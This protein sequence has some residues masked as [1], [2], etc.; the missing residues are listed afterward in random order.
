MHFG[1]I[2]TKNAGHHPAFYIGGNMKKEETQPDFVLN[3]YY[4]DYYQESNIVKV[5]KYDIESKVALIT[6]YDF[7]E[8]EVSYV[9][10]KGPFTCI[11]KNS[12]DKNKYLYYDEDNI[13]YD[14]ITDK[15][16][17]KGLYRAEI[18]NNMSPEEIDELA[19]VLN[20][21]TLDN[22]KRSCTIASELMAI[23]SFALE[24]GYYL[25]ERLKEIG[26]IC[27]DAYLSDDSYFSFSY[28]YNN[29]ASKVIQGEFRYE[30]LIKLSRADII[31]LATDRYLTNDRALDFIN[32]IEDSEKEI[33]DCEYI[34]TDK[35]LDI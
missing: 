33:K 19:F 23:R 30:D 10:V 18:L 11:S 34:Q 3:R 29:V 1:T 21:N 14:S 2:F 8:E 26:E 16:V 20:D 6:N 32:K 31:D 35:E 9:I 13:I 17:A 5:E 27:Y 24:K 25:E 22:L 28:I 7:N 4:G 12:Q 15:D